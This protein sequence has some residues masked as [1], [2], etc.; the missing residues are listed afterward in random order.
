MSNDF[1]SNIISWYLRNQ[2]DL[3]WR[4]TRNPYQIWLSEIILQQT[5]VAQG[6]DYYNR[7]VH[8]FPTVTDLANA[9]EQEVLR[10]WQGL[11][12]YSRAR[13]LHAA[14]R[15][16]QDL[17]QGEFPSHYKEI[18][19]LKGVGDY[20]AAA[21]ASFAFDLPYATVD[22]NVF[23]VLSRYYG[24]DTPIDT[25]SGKKLFD[26][27]AQS[28]L[29]AHD[30]ATHNQAIMEFGALQCVPQSPNCEVC[31]LVDSC[32]A[33]GKGIISELPVKKGKTQVKKVY[34]YYFNVVAEGQQLLRHRSSKGI[35][36][37]M[38]DFPCVESDTPLTLR[39]IVDHRLV[40]GLE[41]HSLGDSVMVDSG[42]RHLLSHRDLNVTF[43]KL[44]LTTPFSLH[45]NDQKQY[46]WV[47]EQERSLYPVPRLIE[48][49]WEKEE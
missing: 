41:E 29:S 32:L 38:Y 18:R 6:L 19:A 36:K 43:F 8:T 3:P 12:Y 34:L 42:I 31:P 23:R 49:F 44:K 37:N 30:P 14:A 33:Y 9:S 5:R 13:N 1:S 22:G 17:Y 39:Q 46:Q 7:F 47:G 21:I 10:L 11:G 45:S 20:T 15:Q 16:I 40:E 4:H 25:T 24:V 35:W 28:V 48:L 26:Q 27:L 2:R